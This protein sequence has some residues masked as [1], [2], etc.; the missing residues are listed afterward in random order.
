[1]SEKEPTLISNILP[2]TLA[3]KIA[4]LQHLNH[5][6]QNALNN[7][8]ANHCSI[9]KQTKNSLVLIVDNSSWAT[10]LRYALP[11]I[12]KTLQIYPEFKNLQKIQYK[13]QKEFISP[14]SKERKKDP[15]AAQYARILKEF[16]YEQ[17]SKTTN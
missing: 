17:K 13:I 9:A 15:K 8:L 10:N 2:D 14:T 7:D 12:I 1:M 4:S 5:I 11:D 3:K 16:A 6:F